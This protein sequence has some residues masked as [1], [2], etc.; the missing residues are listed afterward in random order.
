MVCICAG[1]SF[2]GSTNAA[3]LKLHIVAQ[4]IDPTLCSAPAAEYI[5]SHAS[6]YYSVLVAMTDLHKVLLTQQYRELVCNQL[7]IPV[8]W[9]MKPLSS[10]PVMYPRFC[11]AK[12]R[13]VSARR[14][15]TAKNQTSASAAVG[16]EGRSAITPLGLESRIPGRQHT[17]VAALGFHVHTAV[18]VSEDDRAFATRLARAPATP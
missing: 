17:H 14:D 12:R 2:S 1:V 13:A 18:R 15:V 5:A 16:T 8:R 7:L 11:F 10:A 4:L 3:S 6:P 9:G